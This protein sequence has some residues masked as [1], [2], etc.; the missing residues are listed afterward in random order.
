M[1]LPPEAA[2]TMKKAARCILDSTDFDATIAGEL[3]VAKT[4]TNGLLE[5]AWESL[6]SV[7]S[8]VAERPTGLVLKQMLA[9][10]VAAAWR[11][12]AAP[13]VLD[14]EAAEKAGKR[15]HK[16]V[17]ITFKGLL[18]AASSKAM[19][20]RSV[21]SKASAEE[22]VEVLAAKMAA[23]DAL[24]REEWA[25]ARRAPYTGF[26]EL[27]HTGGEPEV[28]R[29]VTDAAAD[30]DTPVDERVERL[31]HA[32]HVL[33]ESPD[34]FA[35]WLQTEQEQQ[36]E[37]DD[38]LA[39]QAA[40]QLRQGGGIP[41]ALARDIGHDGC[42]ALLRNLKVN[43]G[44]GLVAHPRI[45][46]AYCA[47]GHGRLVS[48][49][50]EE[51]LRHDIPF[52]FGAEATRSRAME[53]AIKEGNA[54]LQELKEAA[55]EQHAHDQSRMDDYAVMMSILTRENREMRHALGRAPRGSESGSAGAGGSETV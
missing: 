29:A 44:V 38:E 8:D 48:A 28:V 37:D 36:Q 26:T 39:E 23:I 45:T 7:V 21:L 18:G 40:F 33:H 24:E 53:D 10:L 22:G 30:V 31:M 47:M 9:R 49:T 51:A 3:P 2:Q 19:R 46:G 27:N 41:R 55:L 34:P 17:D 52:I 14:Q 5:L 20:A 43:G 25:K 12:P 42:V 11:G 1:D 32:Q 6:E 54:A 15:L 35:A 4:L 50:W 13:A 16:Q